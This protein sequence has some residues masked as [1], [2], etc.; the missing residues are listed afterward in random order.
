MKDGSEWKKKK[1]DIR[2]G[3]RMQLKRWTGTGEEFNSV[4]TVFLEVGFEPQRIGEYQI[5]EDHSSICS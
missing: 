1:E 2:V 4:I 3:G 5:T